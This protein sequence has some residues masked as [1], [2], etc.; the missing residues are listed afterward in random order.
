MFHRTRRYTV[1]M[2]PTPVGGDEERALA[3]SFVRDGFSW[4]A[5]LLGPAW[6]AWKRLW[7]PLGVYAVIMMLVLLVLN[8][9]G[10]GGGA[11]AWVF[12]VA[13]VLLGCEAAN[14]LRNRLQQA[15][16]R[17]TAIVSGASLAE[18]E[19]RFFA[20]LDRKGTPA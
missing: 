4:P 18:C 20:G 12:L 15:G 2:P 13:G 14:L 6:L 1:H 9:S 7:V 11:L 8:A 3:T 19:L 5:F 17:E 16:Y 10:Y